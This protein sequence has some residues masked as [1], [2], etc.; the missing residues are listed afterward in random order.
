MLGRWRDVPAT[1]PLWS[2]A[3]EGREKWPAMLN[4]K[5]LGVDPLKGGACLV[6]VGQV[7]K[8]DQLTE[9]G[10]G[11]VKAMT[12]IEWMGGTHFAITPLGSPLSQ[13]REGEQ[14]VLAIPQAK[15]KKGWYA[16]QGAP[17]GLQVIK[18][19]A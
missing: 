2:A 10:T 5:D 9:E 15:G 19:G 16:K 3:V 8:Q 6:I 14:V 13:T 4:P 12:S 1:G 7:G 17:V 18:G 11:E